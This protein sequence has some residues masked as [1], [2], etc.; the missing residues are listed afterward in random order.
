[1]TILQHC[2]HSYFNHHYYHIQLLK[3][4]LFNSLDLDKKG[5]AF[6]CWWYFLQWLDDCMYIATLPVKGLF[7]QQ[8]K[9]HFSVL[10][11]FGLWLWLSSS[12]QFSSLYKC[13]SMFK[14]AKICLGSNVK[15]FFF[16][17]R[18]TKGKSIT[19]RTMILQKPSLWTVI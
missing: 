15:S 6:C 16:E 13:V 7:L 1:M 3:F 19:F 14:M 12:L 17:W 10:H 8:N 5:I 9:I 4:Q 11:L 2:F 18:A